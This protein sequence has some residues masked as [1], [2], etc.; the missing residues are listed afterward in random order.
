MLRVQGYNTIRAFDDDSERKGV[1]DIESIS[2]EM[3]LVIPIGN[4]KT[5]KSLFERVP[6]SCH[7]PTFVH[8][9]CILEDE[10]SITVGRGCIL[11]ARSIFTT[12]IQIGDFVVINLNCTV[13]HDVVM[14]NFV[15][16]MPSVDIGGNVYIESE[17]YI[18]TNATILPGIR[19]GRGSVVAAGAVVTKDVPPNTTVKGVP[20]K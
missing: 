20:A 8:S 1:N 19:I 2:S 6:S 17:A 13:G 7:F 3:S 4:S 9:S 10:K 15:S 14:E 11:T 12:N 5:R 16:V 18:G